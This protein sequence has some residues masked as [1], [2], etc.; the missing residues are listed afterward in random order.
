MQSTL[1]AVSCWLSV[2]P[3]TGVL[4]A[5]LKKVGYSENSEGELQYDPELVIPP[6]VYQP[7]A[8]MRETTQGGQ[9]IE[10]A[11]L[12]PKSKLMAEQKEERAAAISACH[13]FQEAPVR[14]GARFVLFFT[15]LWDAHPVLKLVIVNLVETGIP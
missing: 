2:P 15:S 7:A 1:G 14:I 12:S 8:A 10:Q 6:I 13:K 4:L 9:P 11:V 5:S 3:F